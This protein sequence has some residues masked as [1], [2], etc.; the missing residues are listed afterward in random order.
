MDHLDISVGRGPPTRPDLGVVV[1]RRRE[2]EKGKKARNQ[3]KDLG[4]ERGPSSVAMLH[5]AA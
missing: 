2:E 5:F 3:E 1:G 4:E